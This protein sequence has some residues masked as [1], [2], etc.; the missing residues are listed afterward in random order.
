[1][2]R[3]WGPLFLL[4]LVGE[5][6]AA[7]G[8]PRSYVGPSRIPPPPRVV[9]GAKRIPTAVQPAQPQQQPRPPQRQPPPPPR[10]ETEEDRGAREKLSKM[11]RNLR[12]TLQ[13][14][15]NLDRV[16]VEEIRALQ[17][18]DGDVAA[19]IHQALIG[20]I[21]HEMNEEEI[22]NLIRRRELRRKVLDEALDGV[23]QQVSRLKNLMSNFTASGLRT[24]SLERLQQLQEQSIRAAAVA[25]EAALLEKEEGELRKKRKDNTTQ[26]AGPETQMQSFLRNM[27]KDL[28][29]AVGVVTREMAADEAWRRA[30]QRE[31]AE[32]ETVVK[33]HDSHAGGDQG[34]AGIVS[35]L[36]DHDDNVYV[37]ARPRDSSVH[38]EDEKLIHDVVKLI[39]ASAVGGVLASAAGLPAFF[40]YIA[41]G[42]ILSPTQFNILYN[43]VQIESLAQYGVYFML[44]GLGLE[45]HIERV[46]L[47]WRSAIGGGVLTMLIIWVAASAS[48]KSVFS[49]PVSEGLLIGFCMSL[50]ST[51]VVLKL[52]TEDEGGTPYGRLLLAV[53]VVQDVFLGLM[54]AFIP[55]LDTL[56]PA[57]APVAL[58]M[59]LSMAVVFGGAALWAKHVSAPFVRVI[60]GTPESLL[61][62]CCALCFIFMC[63]TERLHISMEVGCFVYGTTLSALPRHEIE[64]IEHV[65]RPMQDFFIAVFFAAIGLHI[66]PSFLLR[67]AALLVA[68]T[69]AVVAAK[70]FCSFVVFR[71]VCGVPFLDASLVSLGLSQMSE[72][73]FVIAA[74][75]KAQGLINREVYF[76]LLGITAVSLT[77]TPMLWR[78]HPKPPRQTDE[79]KADECIPRGCGAFNAGQRGESKI[80]VSAAPSSIRT[81]CVPRQL[82]A[83]RLDSSEAGCAV[84]RVPTDDLLVP[85]SSLVHLMLRVHVARRPPG[86][87]GP[88]QCVERFPG[89]PGGAGQFLW[90]FSVTVPGRPDFA[91]EALRKSIMA[92]TV[93]DLLADV[94]GRSAGAGRSPPAA[95]PATPP[96]RRGPVVA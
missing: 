20:P 50:S 57:G 16:L 87:P 74:H 54:V 65:T 71:Y 53:L 49:A 88:L 82:A 79:S 27:D 4:S 96:R 70:W 17:S 32:V 62:G 2:G 58:R 7:P 63:I 75:G 21:S 68:C 19:G 42:I 64:R 1:M 23:M 33:V 44:F 94:S 29:E 66:Y 59:L 85:E 92:T 55:L 86:G 47:V 83:A 34:E 51:A 43:I 6:A 40:G 24:G 72:F 9:P 90:G 52:L 91:S 18:G 78:L 13:R 95:S 35:H 26:R 8:E 36:I 37:L 69:T 89:D 41:G 25:D 11:M 30:R 60:G 67:E 5:L 15:L 76:I 80:V 48:L 46:R 10:K 28:G 22:N 12:T 38:Y 84:V 39:V 77:T 31:G 73:S 56:G 93:A 45:F 14:K 3:P 81:S 61:L